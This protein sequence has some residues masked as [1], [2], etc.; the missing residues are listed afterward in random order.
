MRRKK[1]RRRTR[2]PRRGIYILPNIFTTGN[3]FCGFFS[4]I[5]S[6]T[7]TPETNRILLAGAAI[8]CAAIFDLLDGRIAR[9]THTTSAFGLQYD[10]M[11][12]LS[13]FGMAPALLM[14]QWALQPFGRL[15]WLAAFLYFACGALRLARFNAQ[16]SLEHQRFFKGL[17]IPMAAMLVASS[18][19]LHYSFWK[20]VDSGY[21]YII[22]AYCLA[23]LMVSNVPYRSFKEI[24]L[25]Q[26]TSF[27]FAVLSV[28][29]LIV[30]VLHPLIMLFVCSMGYALFGIG[31]GV[32][33]FRRQRLKA[34]ESEVEGNQDKEKLIESIEK[35]GKAVE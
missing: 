3:L 7:A 34:A 35:D 5:A 9:M 19:I 18:V 22:G 12:D 14:Y 28:L 23:F 33:K 2:E 29:V 31:E 15:G 20:A 16:D 13:S 32:V 24:D 10:S 27:R 26:R 11:A 21:Y 30:L 8:I 1:R 6:M 4:I 17:P 25:R